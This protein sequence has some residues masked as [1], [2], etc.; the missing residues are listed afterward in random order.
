MREELLGKNHR[1]LKDTTNLYTTNF[2]KELWF[3]IS[4]GH[5]WRGELKN[6]T[7]NGE[8]VWVYSVISPIFDTQNNIIGYEGISRDTTIKKVLQ[9][10]NQ[11]LTQEN[12]RH[13]FFQKN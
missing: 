2:Y 9:E 10:F 1:V 8:S 13:R 5:T 11:K 6:K 7:K 4:H 3:S 12:D